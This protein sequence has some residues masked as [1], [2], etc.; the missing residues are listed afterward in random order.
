MS[1]KPVQLKSAPG[2]KRDGTTLEGDAHIDGQWVRWQRGLPRK[3][4]GYR[5]ITGDMTEIVR[6][7]SVDFKDGVQYIHGGSTGR[8]D[9]VQVGSSGLLLAINDRTPA[10]FPS[11][12]NQLW[13]FET[14]WDSVAG[15]QRIIG[16][17]AP[18]LANIDNSTTGLVYYGDL[19]ATSALTDTGV[20]GVSGGVVAAHPY[21]FKF[22]SNGQIDWSVPN[23][24]NDFTNAGSGTARVTK[25]KIICGKSLR[26][27]GAGPSALFWSINALV[28]ATF[29]TG[30][31]TWVFDE[32][33]TNISIMSSRSVV[34]YDGVFFWPGV[35]R[36]LMFNGVVRE[37]PNNMNVNWYFDNINRD[38]R[39]KAFTFKVPRWGEI[40]F[41]FPFGSATECTHAVIFNVREN[42]W[43][44]TELPNKGRAG[45]LTPESDLHPIMSG[46]EATDDDKYRLWQH[47]LGLDEVIGNYSSAI[48][49]YFELGEISMVVA[50]Q[51][52][53]SKSLR[54][55]RIEPD[56]VQSGQMSVRVVGRANSRAPEIVS[57]EYVF[58]DTSTP[59]TVPTK[60]VRR[61]LRL[62]FESNVAGGDYQAGIIVGH[63][64]PTD[65]RIES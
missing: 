46:I 8:C 6:G 51:G 4:W 11:N 61:L 18:N 55:D 65:G 25:S 28:R 44:D 20:A 53:D 64:E 2:I 38:H 30:G 1:A 43:Y 50:P 59:E 32:L 57:S 49:S 15:K 29:T 22:G 58:D 36:F 17:A 54:I 9:Q 56:F 19:D 40:W 63:I 10:A 16:H 37:V 5:S 52:A 39:Q 14:I 12:A 45:G 47:E 48:K 35:D 60:D 21:L 7:M 41:C 62:K 13:Q 23:K 33:S 24:P 31:T 42:T 27:N 26:G 34:E 3:M